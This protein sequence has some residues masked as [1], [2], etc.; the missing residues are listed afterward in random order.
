MI[1]AI[2]ISLII[3]SGISKAIM[4]T[5]QFHFDQS[6]FR[7]LGSWWN[8]L[9]SWVNKYRWFQGNKILTWLISN[10]FVLLTDAWHFFQSLYSISFA[11]AFLVSGIYYPIFVAVIVYIA[12]RLVFHI[13]Y[14]YL[15][16]HGKTKNAKNKH[17]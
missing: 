3:I 16:K 12:N 17:L 2:L 5:L 10:P 14:T 11:A 1:L 6:I 9:I 4:D 7:K 8:P 15:F 13:F